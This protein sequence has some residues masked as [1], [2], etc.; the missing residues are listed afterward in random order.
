MSTPPAT[1]S[2]QRTSLVGQ[3]AY[4]HEQPAHKDG[5]PVSRAGSG[6]LQPH[7]ADPTRS[8][9]M[10]ESTLSRMSNLSDFPAPPPQHMTPAHMSLLSSYFHEHAAHAAEHSVPEDQSVV[11]SVT[12]FTPRIGERF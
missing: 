10:T 11:E 6:L 12:T 7:S 1:L 9:Y 2:D 8:S 3:M 4:V 5:I